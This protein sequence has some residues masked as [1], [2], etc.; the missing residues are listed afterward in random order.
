MREPASPPIM[1]DAI[2]AAERARQ[3][4]H[5]GTALVA[6]PAALH[7]ATLLGVIAW[8]R[9]TGASGTGPPAVALLTLV[10]SLVLCALFG[11]AASAVFHTLAGHRAS[12]LAALGPSHL[13]IPAVL[14]A[15]L[16]PGEAV[17][18]A[19][20]RAATDTLDVRQ[21]GAEWL[22][23]VGSGVFIALMVGVGPALIGNMPIWV[24]VLSG[25][26]GSTA[27][28]GLAIGLPR[29]TL[30]QGG[31]M[32]VRRGAFLR[33]RVSVIDPRA[34]WEIDLRDDALVARNG[35][36]AH[37]IAAFDP[38][39]HRRLD[40]TLCFVLGRAQLARLALALTD[41][42]GVPLTE[43]ALAAIAGLHSPH[44]DRESAQDQ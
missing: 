13:D 2:R 38:I 14:Q 9:L 29:R 30:V 21:S 3:R 35:E 8:T 34:G 36:D 33:S 40:L 44:A 32:H 41:R 23:R 19:S 17:G 37:P 18:T 42:A 11:L 16:M 39:Q 22:G 10:A 20:I 25:A 31:I 24:S 6:L 12:R 1:I 43:S 5:L 7:F 28:A 27:Y 15:P 4:L 26:L